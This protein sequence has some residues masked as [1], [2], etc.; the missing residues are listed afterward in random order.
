MAT[1]PGPHIEV[2]GLTKRFGT[3]LA[4]DDLDFDVRP[5]VVTGFL[6]PNGAGKTTTMRVILGLSHP[7]AGTA[8]VGGRHYRDLPAPLREVGAVIDVQGMHPRRRARHHLL[9]LARSNRIPDA[10]VAEVLH[11]VGLH[12]YSDRR[13]GAYSLGMRQRL[14]LAAALLGD[15]PVLVLDE[16]VNGL[17]P[18]GIIWMRRLMRHLAAEGRTV[19]VSSHLMSEMSQ[20]ADR[21]IVISHGRLLRD[22]DIDAFVEASTE[23]HVL[24]RGRPLEVL[25]TALVTMGA[26]AGPGPG[27]G[28]SLDVVGMDAEQIGELAATH[29]VVLHELTPQRTSLEEAFM[30]LTNHGPE[31][32]HSSSPADSSPAADT[33]SAAVPS[34]AS[35]EAEVAP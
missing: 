30:E 29:R 3:T 6:G 33:S 7:T 13:I 9:A 28:P 8:E 18:E 12:E 26:H 15:P 5:G 34:S 32:A 35:I 23:R 19:L 21:V 1:S 11:L 31:Q 24:V 2:R 17:D 22:Q 14:A 4:V 10:R 27:P 25:E 20:T 16:P